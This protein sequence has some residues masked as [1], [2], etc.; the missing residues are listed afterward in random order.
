MEAIYG[1]RFPKTVRGVTAEGENGEILGIAGVAYSYPLQC[2]STIGEEL[3]R[4]PRVIVKAMRQ[5]QDILRKF[6]APVYTQLDTSEP[7]SEQFVRHVGFEPTDLEG[8]FVW[9]E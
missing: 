7:T 2:F 9:R 4:Q 1:Q 3:R 6:D 8:I 5:L